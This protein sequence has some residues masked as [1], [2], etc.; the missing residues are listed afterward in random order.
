MDLH[1]KLDFLNDTVDASFKGFPSHANPMSIMDIKKQNWNL[2]K[3]DIPF[4]AAI[5][6]NDALKNNSTF[7][8]NFLNNAGVSFSPHGKTTMSPQLFKRQLD[9]GAWGITVATYQQFYICW[10]S[11]IRNILMA[12]QLIDYAAIHAIFNIL[13]EN[14]NINFYCLIDSVAGCEILQKAAQSLQFTQQIKVLLELG[15]KGGRTGCRSIDEAFNV[16]KK[17][18]ETP[19]LQL[20]GIECYEGIINTGNS[21]RDVLTIKT[22]LKNVVNFATLCDENQLFSAADEI[23]LTGGGSSYFDLV[24]DSFNCLSFS[25]PTRV[26][27]RSGCYLTHDSKFYDGLFHHLTER[28]SNNKLS[29]KPLKAA[30]EIWSVVQSRPEPTLA[31]LSFGKRDVSYDIDLPIPIKW[32]DST[33]HTLPEK[34]GENWKI[35]KLNDQH[36]YL[37][38]SEEDAVAVGDLVGC[39]IS[40]PCTTFD[41]WKLLYIV[42]DSYGVIDA[43]KTYF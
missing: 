35:L 15:Y 1:N 9:D 36:A 20:A 4:P 10:R 18:S 3:N 13:K 12:N 8:K 33:K 19:L 25:K 26:I 28:S 2:L 39:G 14:T 38:I 34:V 32:F 7:M 37:Q 27:I 21:D 16:A 30:L 43:V 40:H 42:D 17:I 22:L 5:L 11:G 31:I 41:K 6:L 29:K 23:L 24:V